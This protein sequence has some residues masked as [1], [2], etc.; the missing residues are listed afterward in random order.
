MQT[1]TTVGLDSPIRYFR[2]TALMRKAD[3][4][5]DDAHERSYKEPVALF[6]SV[7][8]ILRA[9]QCSLWV[10]VGPDKSLYVR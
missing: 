1:I 8:E 3:G 7:R 10:S 9:G 4:L 2:C 6:I 5:G